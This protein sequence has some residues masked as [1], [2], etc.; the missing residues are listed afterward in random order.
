[1]AAFQAIQYPCD[2]VCAD[3]GRSPLQLVQIGAEANLG[4]N[5]KP[6]AT[7]LGRTCRQTEEMG[8][9]C[10]LHDIYVLNECRWDVLSQRTFHGV[11]SFQGLTAYTLVMHKANAPRM[12]A[13]ESS[14]QHG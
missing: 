13:I 8:R 7:L 12:Q 3:S 11:C 10:S 4:S 1:M 9:R 14:K 2:S 6:L 5:G